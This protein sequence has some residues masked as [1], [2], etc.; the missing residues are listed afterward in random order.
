MSFNLSAVGGLYLS[1]KKK[2][3]KNGCVVFTSLASSW[4]LE[5]RQFRVMVMQQWQEKRHDARAKWLF[6]Q[7]NP[8]AFLLVL[9]LSLHVCLDPWLPRQQKALN[10]KLILLATMLLCKAES[11]WLCYE[12]VHAI[13]YRFCSLVLETATSEHDRMLQVSF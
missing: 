2:E 5:F 9:V 12:R 8:T 11:T 6:C 7:P 4:K 10:L 1:L 3:S 13:I